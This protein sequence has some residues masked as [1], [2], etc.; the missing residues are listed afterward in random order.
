VLVLASA[1]QP[2][3]G[4]ASFLYRRSQR[5]LYRGRLSA[6]WQLLLGVPQG[7]V[8][9]PILFLL[10]TAELFDVIAVCGL[11][12]H[13]YADDTQVYISTPATDHVDAMDRL[14]ACIERI[15]DWMADNHLKL[16]EEKTQIVWLGTRQQLNKVTPRALTLPNATV[17]FSTT[18]KDLGVA[19]DSQ[20]TIA[21]H[22]AALS[23][24]CFF[25]IRQLR[26]I[27]QSLTPDAVKTL[28]YAFVSSRIDYCN[29]ILARVSGQ[30]LQRLQ[31]VQNAAVRLV[32]VSWID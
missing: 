14:A 8:L 13:T 4:S 24:S 27:R 29:S 32:T 20:L 9:G 22:I 17:E 23:R 28:V 5:V 10:Y 31:S 7:S 25:Y 18:V 15:R 6:E 12:G 16:N 19:L 2:T 1:E 26:S 3:I 11:A 21:N 30:L